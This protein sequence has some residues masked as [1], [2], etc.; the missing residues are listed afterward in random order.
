MSDGFPYTRIK[1]GGVIE[2]FTSLNFRNKHVC[3]IE[4]IGLIDSCQSA[5]E[6]KAR[7]RLGTA[8][9]TPSGSTIL[10][11]TSH[12]LAE[13]AEWIHNHQSEAAAG[14][15]TYPGSISGAFKV[16]GVGQICR[17]TYPILTVGCAWVDGRYVV[18]HFVAIT[19]GNYGTEVLIPFQ[20]THI[21][22]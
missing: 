21:H 11:F 3:L 9:K 8:T 22:F 7:Q 1:P 13:F 19:T 14:D 6:A 12:E 5:A 16:D 20:R 15:V 10:C 17:Y 18:D 4:A 2:R